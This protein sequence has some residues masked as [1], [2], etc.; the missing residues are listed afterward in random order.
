[1]PCADETIL[2]SPPSP[3]PELLAVA[4]K[5]TSADADEGEAMEADG[6]TLESKGG[7]RLLCADALI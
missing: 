4:T 7:Y 6:P 3:G 1:M 2:G 5:T